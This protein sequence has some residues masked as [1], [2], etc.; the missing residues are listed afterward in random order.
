VQDKFNVL[1]YTPVVPLKDWLRIDGYELILARVAADLDSRV[2]SALKVV[3]LPESILNSQTVSS[4]LE[5]Y[6]RSPE[7]DKK[8]TKAEP[9]FIEL[10]Q[11]CQE[12][13]RWRLGYSPDNVDIFDRCSLLVRG[14]VKDLVYHKLS[15]YYFL[16]K[17]EVD[18]E[19]TGYVALLREVSHLPR[20]L[21]KLISAGLDAT[22]GEVSAHPEWLTYIDFRFSDFAMP[23]GEISSPQVEHL[24]QTFS[25]LFGKIGLPDP[26]REKV[27]VLCGVR[28][29]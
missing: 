20:R 13:A 24:L 3:G 19:E 7:A 5:E 27:D 18:A 28:P 4:I 16:H 23:I 10:D 14:V 29:Q 6:I 8:L 22:D 21:A 26:D 11:R 9:K 15:G 1:N 2:E 17:L 25:H 12:L